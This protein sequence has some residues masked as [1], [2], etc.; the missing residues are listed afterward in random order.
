MDEPSAGKG[1]QRLVF[2]A[3]GFQ[4]RKHGRLFRLRTG[5]GQRCRGQGVLRRQGPRPAGKVRG[6]SSIRRLFPF[7]VRL[8]R[9][10]CSETPAS[11]PEFQFHRFCGTFKSIT[12]KIVPTASGASVLSL[13]AAHIKPVAGA[14]HGHIEQAP[15]FVAAARPP[16]FAQDST[17]PVLVVAFHRPQY[18]L[19]IVPFAAPFRGPEQGLVMVGAERATGVG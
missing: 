17:Q 2:S 10:G 8:R 15:V 3:A 7:A 1:G 11:F 13:P 12:H 5:R 16:V 19:K 18:P 4:R 9:L 6:F 14:G